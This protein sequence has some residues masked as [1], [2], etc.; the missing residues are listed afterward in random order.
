MTP[1]GQTKNN[2][3]ERLIMD[4]KRQAHVKMLLTT[5]DTL[6]NFKTLWQNLIALATARTQFGAAIK[7]ITD[8]ELNQAGTTTGGTEDKHAARVA[9]CDAAALIGGAVAAWADTQDDHELY[10]SVDFSAPDLM[11]LSEQACLTTCQTILHAGIAHLAALTAVKSLAQTDLDDL[12]AAI[13]EFDTDLTLPRQIRA[14]ISGAT[15]R[16]PGLITVADR[17]LERQ[18]DKHLERF[19]NANSGFYAA[20]KVARI[21][22]SQG[23][24]SSAAPAPAP[25][26][27]LA[28]PTD[29]PPTPPPPTPPAQ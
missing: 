9:M 1:H 8:E 4:S 3:K 6:D 16:I 7:A 12:Q 24:G 10:A 25:K 29:V 13:N 23:G 21:I 27:P 2:Q 14:K 18:L 26:P 22:V 20:Y 17:I 5:R 15:S 11:H 28:N 19:K